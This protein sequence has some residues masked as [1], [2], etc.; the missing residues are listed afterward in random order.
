MG[1]RSCRNWQRD[2]ATDSAA[3]SFLSQRNHR[4]G[5]SDDRKHGGVV[6]EKT[7]A[8]LPRSVRDR[9][10]RNTDGAVC[11]SW[12]LTLSSAERQR[13]V[14]IIAWGNAPGELAG[15]R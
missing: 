5:K 6:L 1:L 13:R 10:P 8:A 9:R 12:R 3:R 4:A 7:G 11:L 14:I 2:E 15:K